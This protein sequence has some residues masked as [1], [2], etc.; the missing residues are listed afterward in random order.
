L[1]LFAADALANPN[2]YETDLCVCEVCGAVS[3]AS[4]SSSRRGC[5]IHPFG[6]TDGNKPPS[7]RSGA[8]RI[9]E[10]T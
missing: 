8:R 1:A 10:R 9:T 4:H 3:F 6:G 5:A 2:Q 7:S